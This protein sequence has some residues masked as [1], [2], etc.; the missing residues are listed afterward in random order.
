MKRMIFGL[1]AALGLSVTLSAPASAQGWNSPALDARAQRTLHDFAACVAAGEAARARAVL[2]M[3]YRTSDYNRELVQL[4]QRSRMCL[5]RPRLSGNSRFFAGRIA[6]ALVLRE[7]RGGELGPRV[8]HD[9]A[10]PALQ[11]RD[12]TELMAICTVRGAPAETA[13]LFA[14][15]PAGHEEAA[16]VRALTPQIGRC[17]AAGATGRFNR[18]AVRSMLALAAWRLTEHNAGVRSAAATR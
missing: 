6:E 18:A 17:L 3:D 7:L 13:A 12:E 9:P 8:A 2:A 10:R 14:T 11:A 4:I 16:A 1:A 15:R 5:E